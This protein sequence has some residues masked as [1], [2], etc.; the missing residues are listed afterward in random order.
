[1][2]NRDI[3]NLVNF[4]VSEAQEAFKVAEHL[5]EKEDFSYAL[6]LVIWPWKKY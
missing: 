6:F 5:L 2:F 4:W 3:S 1:M